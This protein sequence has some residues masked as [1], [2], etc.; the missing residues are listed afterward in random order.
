MIDI[1]TICR[2]NPLELEATLKSIDFNLSTKLNVIVIDASDSYECFRICQNYRV[3]YNNQIGSGI[4]NAM[5][6]GVGLSE[7]ESIIFMNSGDRFSSDFDMSSFID[8]NR[9]ILSTHIV[10]GDCRYVYN[11]LSNLKSFSS[12]KFKGHWWLNKLPVHQSVFCP[13]MYL[14]R[15]LFSEEFTI[16]SDTE[17]LLNAF[18]SL[19]YKYFSKTISEFEIDGVS[20]CPLT[21]RKTLVHCKEISI[22]YNL[23]CASQFGLYFKQILKLM[24]IKIIGYDSY[25]KIKGLVA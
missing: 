14:K 15:N 21:I 23:G 24:I 17:F 22:V 18:K 5:N 19:P 25:V 7:G 13:S 1:I 12:F 2:N 16:V 9:E 3:N 20:S 8:T 11:E 10:F 4:Y 6:Q